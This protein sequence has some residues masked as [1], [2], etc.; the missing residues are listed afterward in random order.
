MSA[1]SDMVENAARAIRNRAEQPIDMAEAR[2]LAS[3]ALDASWIGELVEALDRGAEALSYALELLEDLDECPVPIKW[4]NALD[5][6]NAALSRARATQGTETPNMTERSEDALKAMTR[7]QIVNGVAYVIP[8][9]EP[10][11]FFVRKVG[12]FGVGITCRWTSWGIGFDLLR[13]GILIAVG[14]LFIWVAHIDRQLAEPEQ[15][16]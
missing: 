12:A 6:M 7:K 5:G 2:Y 8:R 3:A 13:A 16:T 10:D 9:S 1:D 4:C 15:S 11:A 14:P